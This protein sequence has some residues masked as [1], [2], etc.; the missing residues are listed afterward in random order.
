M[1]A[2]SKLSEKSLGKSYR[3]PN[4]GFEI[5]DVKD[6]ASLHR[7]AMENRKAFGKR[8]VASKILCGSKRLRKS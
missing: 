3:M 5:V 4:F 6:T 8:L 2:V 7:I 1:E